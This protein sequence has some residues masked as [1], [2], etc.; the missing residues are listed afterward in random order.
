MALLTVGDQF[1]DYRLTAVVGGDLTD[2]GPDEVFEVI[3]STERKNGYRVVF[4]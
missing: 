1:P 4:F 2:K 3:D